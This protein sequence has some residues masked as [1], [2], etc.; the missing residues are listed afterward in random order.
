MAHKKAASGGVT[1]GIQVAGKRFGI[2]KFGG[3]FVKA[4]N[5]IVRQKGTKYYAGKNTSMGRD[6]TIYARADGTVKFRMMTGSRRG[7]KA[8]DVVRK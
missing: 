3:E 6:F 4:G 2:K 7:K 8:V 1:Q 5:I